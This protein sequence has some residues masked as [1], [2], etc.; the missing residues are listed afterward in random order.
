MSQNHDDEALFPLEMG[1][2]RHSNQQ[3]LVYDNASAI[4]ENDDDNQF[5]VDDTGADLSQTR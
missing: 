3:I 2:H 4:I 1:D 5:I